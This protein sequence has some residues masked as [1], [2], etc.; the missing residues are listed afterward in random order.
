MSAVTKERLQG[1]YI[2][3]AETQRVNRRSS[4]TAL[5]KFLARVMPG[6]YPRSVQRVAEVTKQASDGREYVT[7]ERV[8]F[9]EMPTLDACRREWET[10][11]GAGGDWPEDEEARPSVGAGEDDPY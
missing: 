8:Y 4:P 10:R 3:Y 6:H 9:Y 2:R 1:D 5:G 11:Y 7:R